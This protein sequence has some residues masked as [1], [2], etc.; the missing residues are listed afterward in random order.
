[1]HTFCITMIRHG[2]EEARSLHAG[3]ER[4]GKET[5][6]PT[7]FIR[8]YILFIGIRRSIRTLFDRVTRGCGDHSPLARPKEEVTH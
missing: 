6:E 3:L 2:E 5:G 8:R 4:L 7:G 1:V